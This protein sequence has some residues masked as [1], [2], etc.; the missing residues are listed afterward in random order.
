MFVTR[1]EVVTDGHVDIIQSIDRKEGE[2]RRCRRTLY[3]VQLPPILV[4]CSCSTVCT[5]QF[6]TYFADRRKD[7]SEVSRMPYNDCSNGKLS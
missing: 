3:V 6:I 5:P 1:D 2:D 4:I 7:G